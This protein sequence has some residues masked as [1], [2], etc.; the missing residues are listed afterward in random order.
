MYLDGILYQTRSI[1]KAWLGLS[2]CSATV[3]HGWDYCFIQEVFHARYCVLHD[4][5]GRRT[6]AAQPLMILLLLLEVKI[7]MIMIKKTNI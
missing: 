5:V 7:Y 2:Q 6:A 4:W 1:V 3:K